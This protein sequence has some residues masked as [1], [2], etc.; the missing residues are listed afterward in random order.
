MLLTE[1]VSKITHLGLKT[2]PPT[3][4]L[5]HAID[6][7]LLK[8]AQFTREI[9]LNVKVQITIIL[10][11]RLHSEN[12]ENLFVSLDCK[13]IIQIKNSLLPVRVRSIGRCAESHPLVAFSKFDGKKCYQCMNVVIT[14]KLWI[15]IKRLIIVKLL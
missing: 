14:T 3:N 1:C 4:H 5:A 9:Q 10:R 2:L 11:I 7:V 12:T 8:C 13:I 15:K 6:V